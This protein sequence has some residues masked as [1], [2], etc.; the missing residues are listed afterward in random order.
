MTHPARTPAPAEL[1]WAALLAR[2]ILGLQF[3]MAGWWKVFSL[4]PLAHARGMFV[5]AFAGSWIPTWLLWGLGA[6]IPVVELAAGLLLLVGWR[7][8]EVGAALVLLL[9]T[10]T[11]G[12]LL[13]E[14]LFVIMDHVFPRAVLLF[15]LLVIPRHADRFTLDA[16]LAARRPERPA[17]PVDATS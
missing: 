4:T 15:G 11:Y 10:V 13:Q 3:L 5:E 8:R 14:P 7:V 2:G 9:L 6:T 12:H 1:A 16:V 17:S